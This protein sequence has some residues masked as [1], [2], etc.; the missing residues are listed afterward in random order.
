MYCPSLSALGSQAALRLRDWSHPLLHNFILSD[1]TFLAIL[2]CLTR[3]VLQGQGTT[4]RASC[5]LV[6]RYQRRPRVHR[7]AWATRTSSSPTASLASR[8]ED[9]AELG[10]RVV[11]AP[12]SC[13]RGDHCGSSQR[14]R[15]PV[16]GQPK[17]RLVGLSIFSRSR[18]QVTACAAGAVAR[19]PAQR[20]VVTGPVWTRACDPTCTHRWRCR[21]VCVTTRSRLAPS[22]RHALSAGL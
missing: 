12:W 3:H 13:E 17:R 7:L 4:D 22:Q 14:H 11:R 9:G 2:C 15:A 8:I 19:P 5:G 16:V 10:A 1:C 6:R 18:T 20:S 21:E